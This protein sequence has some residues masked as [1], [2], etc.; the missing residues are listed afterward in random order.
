MECLTYRWREHVGPNE[1]YGSDYRSRNELQPWLASDQ[2][3][4]LA[5]MLP[6]EVAERVTV[7]VTGQIDDAFEFAAASPAPDPQEL[8]EHVYAR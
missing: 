4:R 2:V 6:P 8:L 7:G 1:D 5:R 3:E